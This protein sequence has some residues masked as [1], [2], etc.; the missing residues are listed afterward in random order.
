MPIMK[1]FQICISI[2]CNKSVVCFIHF[3]IFFLKMECFVLLCHVGVGPV[4]TALVKICSQWPI[5]LF[6]WV[7]AA[8]TLS[9]YGLL[10]IYMYMYLITPGD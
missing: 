2:P 6:T 10:L 1:C 7:F 4:P 5:S 8:P 9:F 3:I